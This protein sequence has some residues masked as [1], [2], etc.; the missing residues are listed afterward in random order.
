LA[1]LTFCSALL[2]MLARRGDHL[3]S[4]QSAKNISAPAAQ[5]AVQTVPGT[6]IRLVSD[7]ELLAMFPGR[8]V[9]LV[10][11]PEDRKFV[12]LDEQR[13]AKSRDGTGGGLKL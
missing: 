3:S 4:Q 2:V 13:Q 6:N 5:P 8:P 10:G 1:A 9:A 7:E 11:P 12:F